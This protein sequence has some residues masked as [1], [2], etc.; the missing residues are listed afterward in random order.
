MQL[1][2]GLNNSVPIIAVYNKNK[3]L[4][5][6]EVVPPQGTNLQSKY[7]Y[8]ATTSNVVLFGSERQVIYALNIVYFQGCSRIKILTLSWPPTS[9][10]VK[11]MFL[12]STVSTLNPE[13]K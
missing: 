7:K 9:Q 6:L 10:T 5:V 4:G 13:T 11:L 12:Y 3:T 1:I 2:S 8:S